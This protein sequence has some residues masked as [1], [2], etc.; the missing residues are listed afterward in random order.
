MQLLQELPVSL[1]SKLVSS[2]LMCK[3]SK[4]SCTRR[5]PGDAVAAMLP[6]FV[7]TPFA[8]AASNRFY[9][10]LL[11]PGTAFRN[12]VGTAMQ[13]VFDAGIL[14]HNKR[15][16]DAPSTRGQRCLW[17]RHSRLAAAGTLR[18]PF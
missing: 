10:L 15:A 11:T 7:L 5:A 14:L 8:G 12:L 18:R 2:A 4:R 1:R 16:A 17:N 9:Q 6:S 13:T 3:R